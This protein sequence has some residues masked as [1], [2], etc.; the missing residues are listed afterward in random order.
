MHWQ[1]TTRQMLLSGGRSSMKQHLA[2]YGNVPMVRAH[3][4]R[5]KRF[6]LVVDDELL[7]CG[8]LIEVEPLKIERISQPEARRR[9]PNAAQR[10]KILEAQNYCCLYCDVSLDGYVFYRKQV[11]KIKITWDHMTPYAYSRDNHHE[12]FAATCQFCNAWKS[13]LIFKTVEEVRAYVALKWQAEGKA[14]KDLRRNQMPEEVRAAPELAKVLQPAMPISSL[15]RIT[16]ASKKPYRIV[17][18]KTWHVY[19]K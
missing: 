8:R 7:C 2:V 6:S 3:C 18:I 9:K 13:S 1:C 11:R 15:V 5:C 17:S 4:Y 16:P 10:Q 19:E 12:N 14:V